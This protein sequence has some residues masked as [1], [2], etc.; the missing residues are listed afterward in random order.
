MLGSIGSID[1]DVV[2]S[3]RK[4]LDDAQRQLAQKDEEVK[5]MEAKMFGQKASTLSYSLVRLY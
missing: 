1:G 5:D 4:Q 3:L 2:Q